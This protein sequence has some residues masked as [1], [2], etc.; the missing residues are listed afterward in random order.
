MIQFGKSE[1]V[2]I[3]EEIWTLMLGLPIQSSNTAI[4]TGDCG[5]AK[6]IS[7][8]SLS[9]CIQITGA[10]TGAVRIDCTESLARRAAAAFLGTRSDEVAHEQVLDA[11]GV[12]TN[13]VAGGIKPMLPKPCQISLPSVVKGTDYEL[14]IRK[15]VVILTSEFECEDDT[16]KISVLE[17]SVLPEAPE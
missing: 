14:N 4:C 2:G 1:V 9:A 11:L 10:W 6:K 15:G 8:G 3:V 17:A 16:L 5:C 12:V 7:A 13:M